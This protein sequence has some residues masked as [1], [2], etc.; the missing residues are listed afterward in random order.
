ML[1]LR[2]AERCCGCL[3]LFNERALLLLGLRCGLHRVRPRFVGLLQLLKQTLHLR[4][5]RAALL[6]LCP[7]LLFEL[8]DALLRLLEFGE[9][10]LRLG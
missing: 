10:A 3:Q 8:L 5:H 6:A 9:Q 4:D 2:V 7:I 1:C